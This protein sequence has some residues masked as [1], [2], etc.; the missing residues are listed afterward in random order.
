MNAP[1]FAVLGHPNEGKSSVVSTL[2]E[3]D[4]VRVSR[5]PGETTRCHRYAIEIGG[6]T[7]LEIVDTPGFQNPSATLEWLRGWE[8]PE[9]EMLDAFIQQH[10]AD[11]A[12][13]H[14][15]EL[16][17]PLRDRAGIL[18]VADASRP[19]R[20]TDKRE[21]ELLRLIGLPRMALLNRK[22][23]NRDHVHSWKEA[24]NRRFNLVREFNAHHATFTERMSLLEAMALLNP[25]QEDPLKRLRGELMRQWD[26]RLEEAGL[27]LEE[28]LR[29]VVHHKV[30]RRCDPS[31][32]EKPQREEVEAAYREDLRQL[33]AR[34]RRDWR[35]LF[36]HETLPG[37]DDG[38]GVLLEDLFTEKVWRLLGLTRGQLAG[39]GFTAGAALGAGADIA[40]GGVTF[41]V[42]TA[43]AALLGGLGGWMGAPKLGAKR[44]PFPGKRTL[45][46]EKLR[47]GPLRD[48]Q[49]VFVLL[50][51]SLLYL[52]R[53]MNWAHAR[54]DHEAFLQGLRRE[55]SLVRSWSDDERKIIRRWI[56]AVTTY[57]AV[58]PEQASSDL[59][60]LLREKLEDAS[61][62]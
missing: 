39:A 27:I 9:E 2:T 21:M 55:S 52:T 37:L 20:E 54:R 32:P 59:Q 25:E 48:P 49:L 33:E 41:G 17:E 47:V 56:S 43:G 46:S 19:L 36:Q 4:R 23:E 44:L 58:S 57:G 50:D 26:Y 35:K 34:A 24:L 31:K 6:R 45:A 5:T 29:R 61:E 14:D 53:L 28:L 38:D 51:R 8:G 22:R 12:F 30:Q 62:S 15:L 60:S 3:N 18:Y 13:H 42:F 11:P 7:A 10:R 16:L 1:K 40:A